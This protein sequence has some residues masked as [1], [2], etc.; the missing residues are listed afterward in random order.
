LIALKLLLETLGSLLMPAEESE[1]R[2]KFY[3]WRLMVAGSLVVVYGVVFIMV[4][5]LAGFIPGV[6]SVVLANDL[7]ERISEQMTPL[8]K[9][10]E[11]QSKQ[12][13][14]TSD[15]LTAL[16][17]V[18]T[19]QLADSLASQIRERSVWLCTETNDRKRETLTSEIDRLQQL[20]KRYTGDWYHQ[21]GCQS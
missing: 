10:V 20:Y 8:K 14:E 9:Q 12:L 17:D 21:R 13:K 4:L 15:K 11:D 16:N 5:W 7:D 19:A 18:V 6:N 1:H 3:T 2:S